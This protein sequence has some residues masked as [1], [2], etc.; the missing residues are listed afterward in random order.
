M[1]QLTFKQLLVEENT[2]KKGG[3]ISQDSS[4]NPTL[5]STSSL[6]SLKYMKA[7]IIRRMYSLET[8]SLQFMFK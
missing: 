6:P 3:F 1:L 7:K 8:K 4:K 2:H 5:N